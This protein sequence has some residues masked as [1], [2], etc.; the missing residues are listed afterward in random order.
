MPELEKKDIASRT[1][2]TDKTD[3]RVR[4]TKAMLIQAFVTLLETKPIKDITVKELCDTADLNRGT[5]YLHYKDIY[6][7]IEQLET[8]ILN[9]FQT[10]IQHYDMNDPDPSC[11][12]TLLHKIFQFAADNAA[13]CR[14]LLS[15][16][17]DISFLINI[18]SLFRDFYLK[19]CIATF[20]E[21]DHSR[22]EYSYAFIASGCVG[23]IESWLSAE[24][25]APPEEIATL[26]SNIIGAGINSLHEMNL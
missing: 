10:L 9:E 1:L 4:R 21:T 26:A 17:G 19:L 6:D 20:G 16:N 14:V 24:Q 5:F 11:P 2:P 7:M 13:L 3:R 12:A 18:K 8:D 23:L 15:E 22:Y 25:L